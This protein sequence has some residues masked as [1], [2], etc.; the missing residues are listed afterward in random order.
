MDALAVQREMIRRTIKEHLDKEKR[1]RPQGIKVLCLFFIDAVDKYRQYDADGN[2]VK[3]DYARI[4]EEEYR[5]LAKHPDYQTLFKEVDLTRAAEEVH[6][7]YFSIDKKG[8][9]TDTDGEQPRATATT[10]SGAYNLIM[11]EKEK[12]LSFE[13]P[14]KFIFSHSA[15]REGWDNPNVFQICAL[16]DIGPSASAGRP[17]AAACACAS[18]RTASACA[19]SRSTRSPSSPPRATSSSPRTCRRRS[20][21]TPASASASSSSTSSRRRRRPAPTARPR[22]WASSSRRRSGST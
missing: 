14:L 10:P 4:F 5:R 15:L 7:G 20:R 3:G 13:T 12:L 18:T 6:N 22:R 17:S 1:L 16:R 21:R 2:P 9:W 11:R 19:A 8:G